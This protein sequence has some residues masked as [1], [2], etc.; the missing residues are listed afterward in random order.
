MYPKMR[1]VREGVCLLLPTMKLARG[2]DRGGFIM[3]FA[4]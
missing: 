4:G 3:S 1:G 2:A